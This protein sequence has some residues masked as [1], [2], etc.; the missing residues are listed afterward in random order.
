MQGSGGAPREDTVSEQSMIIVGAGIAGLSTGCYAQMNGLKSRI[1]EMH[2]MPGGLCTAWTRKGY[3][4]DIS[5]HMLVGS[6]AGPVHE[7]WRELGAVQGRRFHY[8]DRMTR[9]ESGDKVLDVVLDRAGLEARMLALSPDDAGLTREFLDIY[10]GPGLMGGLSLKPIEITGTLDKLRMM[11]R[12]L[13]LMGKFRR[14]GKLTIQ[15]FAARFKD[16]FLGRAVRYLIDAP[17]WPMTGYPLLGLCGFLQ[18]SVAQAGVPIGGSLKVIEAIAARYQALG[19]EVRYRSRVREVIIADNR[20]KGIRLED[21]SE[22]RA[23]HIVWAADGHTLIFDLLGGRYISDDIRRMYG[24]WLPVEPL[25]HVCLG[26]AR[27]MTREP[28][29]VIFEAEQAIRVGERDHKWLMCIN[30][31]FDPTMAP[32]GKTAFEVWYATE[33]DFWQKLS[34]DRA[35]Y[36]AEKERIARET[37]AALDKRWPGLAAQVEVIDVPTP[38]TY[39]RYTGNWQGS[40]DGWYVTAEN[41]RSGRLRS[42]PGLA[43]LY[44][45]GQWTAPFTGTVI[46]ALSGRQAIQLLCRREGRRFGATIPA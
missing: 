11:L 18:A 13:P 22:E 25:V 23:E 39:V 30:H 2:T 29:R 31:A 28:A 17:G 35:R 21:G 34:A 19:G 45:V 24:Q 9:I 32:P 27:D 6:Q 4:F 40:P 8:H 37:I 16:S 15:E 43:N 38:A 10:C 1:F 46:A 33:C 42:L 44:T 3:T 41:M 12:I 5:M 20:A 14:Y 36:V 7:M 26:V